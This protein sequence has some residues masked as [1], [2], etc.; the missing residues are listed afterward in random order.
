MLNLNVSV[1]YKAPAKL[2][3]I[4]GQSFK[5]CLFTP[6]EAAVGDS[7]P[8]RA[9]I[10]VFFFRKQS[11]EKSSLLNLCYLKLGKYFQMTTFSCS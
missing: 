7:I 6:S 11:V 3:V 8:P 5:P 4:S 1:E 2:N 9:L 10:K